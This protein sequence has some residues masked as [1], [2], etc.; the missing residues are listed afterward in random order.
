MNMHALR[1][2]FSFAVPLRYYNAENMI[3]PEET[4]N[5][6]MH[7]FDNNVYYLEEG[8]DYSSGEHNYSWLLT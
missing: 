5:T 3:P 2:S 7:D 6:F 1:L 8:S 4:E